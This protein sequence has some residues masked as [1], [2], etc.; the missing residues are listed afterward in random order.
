M[1]RRAMK[2]WIPEGTCYCYGHR[3]T[4][5]CKWLRLNKKVDYQESGYCMYLKL[6]D[7]FKNGTMLLWDECKE[8]GVKNEISH[9]EKEPRK[10]K[11]QKSFKD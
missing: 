8:C 3:R 5:K 10:R 2:K 11:W 6:G 1:K 7:W 4:G 9:W